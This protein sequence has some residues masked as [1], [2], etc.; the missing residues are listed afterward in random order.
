MLDVSEVHWSTNV[1]DLTHR[2]TTCPAEIENRK[3]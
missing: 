1:D 2:Y 3:H